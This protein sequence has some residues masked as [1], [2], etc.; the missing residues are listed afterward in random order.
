MAE[1]LVARIRLAYFDAKFLG[2][3][4]LK[5]FVSNEAVLSND[6]GRVANELAPF[7]FL[8]EECNVDSFLFIALKLY[9]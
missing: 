6:T 5:P 4:V 7:G 9:D 2:L 1:D 8:P 3:T